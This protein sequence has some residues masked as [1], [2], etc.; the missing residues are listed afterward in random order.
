MKWRGHPLKK[1][2]YIL[3]FLSIL[4]LMILFTACSKDEPINQNVQTVA[5]TDS[6]INTEPKTSE[7]LKEES[8][9]SKEINS[10]QNNSIPTIIPTVITN[11]NPTVTPMTLPIVSPTDM[12]SSISITSIY[13]PSPA[14]DGGTSEV[15][16]NNKIVAIDAGHQSK[17]NYQEEPIGPGA[18]TTKPKVS[19]G[20]QG[21]FTGAAEY[22]LNLVIA[23]KVEKELSRRGYEI[24]MIRKTN[25]VNLSN[26]ERAKIANESGAD[27]LI[28]IHADGAK[29]SKVHGVSTLYPSK[30][31]PYV[32]EL[33]VSSYTLSKAVVDAICDSTG[34]KNRG[35]IARDDMSGI[36]WCTIPVSII[37]MGYM[38]NKTEDKLMQTKAYQN[39]IV[40]GICDGI[41]QYFK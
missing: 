9:D 12:P 36:N 37:E 34:A 30:D 3:L 11:V 6:M 26:K 39:K 15:S 24:V 28:R 10:I 27:I 23:K 8:V 22:K 16:A 35:S 33:S 40:Q 29:D 13:E 7:P 4:F 32:P 41:D 18:T 25:N 5:S 14:P 31:N 19:S 17:G 1:D 38:T 2:S 20:T 21:S